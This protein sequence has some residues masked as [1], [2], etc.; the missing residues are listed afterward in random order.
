MVQ[1]LLLV[2]LDL[3]SIWEK[4]RASDGQR[5]VARD[6]GKWVLLCKG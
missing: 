5:E 1:K 3:S 2:G 4:V 6:K